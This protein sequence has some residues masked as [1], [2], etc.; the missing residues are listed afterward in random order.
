MRVYRRF[1]VRI[2]KISAIDAPHVI[3]RDQKGCILNGDPTRA[4]S[5]GNRR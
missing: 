5:S 1:I 4:R 3:M 2:D